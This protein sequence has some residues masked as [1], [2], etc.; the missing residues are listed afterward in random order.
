M[1]D[2]ASA[3]LDNP[4]WSALTGAHAE[5]AV[6]DATGLV[7]RYPAEIGFFAAVDEFTADAWFAL[8]AVADADGILLLVRRELPAAP[9]GVNIGNGLAGHQMVLRQPIVLDADD[10]A[11]A[12]AVVDLGGGDVDEMLELVGLAK[13][14]PFF[15]R[16]H[17]LGGYVGIRERGRL[18]AMAGQRMSPAGFTEISAVCTHPDARGRR[19][20][21]L[22]TAVVA[23]R[24]LDRGMTPFLH[25]AENNEN[26]HRLYGRLG[27]ETRAMIEFAPILA[28]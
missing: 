18:I 4:V 5:L 3:E 21:G 15:A 27:F 17:E 14:G 25:V 6:T 23:N 11:Q 24:A 16:T 20:G 22:I 9:D 2:S 28:G 13:P 10:E 12:A 1:S 7:K 26:A 8:Q 19:L